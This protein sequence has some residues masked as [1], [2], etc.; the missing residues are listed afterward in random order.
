MKTEDSFIIYCDGGA[1]GNPGPAAYGFAVY[2]S[3][4]KLLF[5][6]GKAIGITTNNVAE[7]SAVAAALKYLS[8]R[9]V[10]SSQLSIVTFFLDSQLVTEQLSGRWKIKNENLRNLFFTIRELEQ[11]IGAKISYKHVFRE[12]NKEADRMVNLALDGLK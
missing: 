1:R 9:S 5:E 4:N 7:Y 3:S 12:Q 6:E 2:D 11:K 8:E 10:V